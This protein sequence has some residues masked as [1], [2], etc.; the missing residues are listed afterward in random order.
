[1]EA[2]P[3]HLIDV[4]DPDE[5]WSLAIL[6]QQQPGQLPAYTYATSCL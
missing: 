2:V 1:M 4:A 5:P 3:H 6:L